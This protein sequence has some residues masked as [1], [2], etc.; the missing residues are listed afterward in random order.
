[1]HEITNI[2]GATFIFSP[3]KDVETASL[4]VFLKVGSRFEKTSLRGIS[5]FL[6]HMVFKG[7][8]HYSYKEIKQEIEGRGG[9]LNG[10]TSQESTAYYAHFLNKNLHLTLDILLDMVFYPSLSE[11]DIK[12]ERNVILEEIKMYNDLPS[13]RAASILDKLLWPENSLGEEIIGSFTTVGKMQKKD[14]SGFKNVYYEPSNIIIS[15][16][17]HANKE[18]V[19]NLLKEKIAKFSKQVNLKYTPPRALRG[20]H[21]KIE[22]KKLEQSHLCIGFRSISYLNEQRFV[23]E[24]LN[25]I[26]GGN[27]SSRLFEEVREKKAL[28]YEISTDARKYRDS[29]AF[30]IHSGLDKSRIPVAV[31]SIFKELDKIK[32]RKVS[33]K[34][35]TRAKDYILGQITMALERP[36]GRMFY[37]AESFLSLGKIY[38]LPEIKKEIEKISAEDIR[39]LAQK[40]FTFKNLCVSCVGDIEAKTEKTIKEKIAVFN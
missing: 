34:E 9:A 21:I 18:M 28:C 31:S 30:V 38:S 40:I 35:L 32:S 6:E 12:K 1:M 19:K 8:K 16:S 5:H 25:T 4:G 33:D 20:T 13:S 22:N 24:V 23:V 15:C 29:G 27:M 17:G 10:F 39:K 36:Q 3:F 7:S 14:L 11:S 26:L 2:N 37:L